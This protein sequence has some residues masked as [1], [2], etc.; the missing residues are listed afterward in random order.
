MPLL[1]A[2]FLLGCCAGLRTLTAP[3]VLWLMR[4]RSAVAYV[5]A[6]FAVLEYAGD[7]SPKAPPRT[8]AVGL[9]A[10]VASGA[11]CG[12]ALLAFGAAGA[13]VMAGVAVGAAGAVVGAY[14]GLWL[15][16]RAVAAIGRVPAA[17]VEDALA[18]AGAAAIVAFA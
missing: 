2:A 11:F 6:V 15:R 7:L 17:I 14:A 12:W 1:L 3:A 13:G 18:I 9:I 5:L 8:K 16:V 4:H 10:R